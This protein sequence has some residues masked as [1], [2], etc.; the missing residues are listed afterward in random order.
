MRRI[1]TFVLLC[2]LALPIRGFSQSPRL[3]FA[4]TDHA[5]I[6]PA[7]LGTKEMSRVSLFFKNQY[8]NFGQ[9]APVTMT[10]SANVPFRYYGTEQGFG[11]F[12]Q[13]DKIGYFT[14]INAMLGYAY[15]FPLGNGKLSAG[16]YLGMINHNV[17]FGDGEWNFPDEGSADPLVPI[18][19]DNAS[20]FDMGLGLAYSTSKWTLGLGMTHVN[21]PAV[22]QG[23]AKFHFQPEILGNLSY[24]FEIESLSLSLEP[25]LDLRSSIATTQAGIGAQCLWMEKYWGGL[26][27][28]TQDALALMGGLSLFDFAFLGVSYEYPLS[29]LAGTNTGSFEMLLNVNFDVGLTK[30]KKKYKSIRY[31]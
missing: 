20:A 31:L 5:V 30:I 19:T 1:A 23:N 4:Y 27:Y 15:H 8:M 6:N 10:M 12:L 17:N 26:T 25:E 16:A 11:L 2:C 14:Q 13:N 3:N 7:Y 18:R 29:G 21:A 22:G 24:K 28:W 9:G